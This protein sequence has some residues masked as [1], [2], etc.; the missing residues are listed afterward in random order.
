M[1]LQAIARTAGVSKALLL[2]HFAGKS[3]LLAAVA[4]TLGQMSAARLR[5]AAA[6]DDA[7]EAWRALV[8]DEST[9]G[10]L[11]LLAALSLELELE[12][13][14]LRQLRDARAAAAAVLASA[15]LAGMQLTPRIPA[16]LL[17]RV[18]LRQLDGVAVGATRA[19][20]PAAALDAE[21]DAF[22]LALLALGR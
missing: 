11:A 2:Y 9:R 17:G 20:L 18:L 22:A 1:S 8:R 6:S 4:V 16:T 21:L 13:E 7:L 12:V 15:L 5:T 14:S 3:T 10:E 19:G